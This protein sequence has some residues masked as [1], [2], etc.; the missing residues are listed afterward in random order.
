MLKLSFK[1]IKK[2][3]RLDADLTDPPPP[4]HTRQIK[5]MKIPGWLLSLFDKLLKPVIHEK[6]CTV[7]KLEPKQLLSVVNIE[8]LVNLEKYLDE[9]CD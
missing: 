5:F 1:L 2:Q 7:D 9:T 3:S 8:A 6:F 4:T